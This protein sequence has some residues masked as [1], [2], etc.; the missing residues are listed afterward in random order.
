MHLAG[1]LDIMEDEAE[2]NE[3]KNESI[4]ES[5]NDQQKTCDKLKLTTNWSP[6]INP[7]VSS[8]ED[9]MWDK[10]NDIISQRKNR[11]ENDKCME[12]TTESQLLMDRNSPSISLFEIFNEDM[13]ADQYYEE[14]Q[15][16]VQPQTV[17]KLEKIEEE[18]DGEEFLQGHPMV[19]EDTSDKYFPQNSQ[20]PSTIEPSEISLD[21]LSAV[22]DEVDINSTDKPPAPSVTEIHCFKHG[23]EPVLAIN[24]FSEEF[25][26]FHCNNSKFTERMNDRGKVTKQIYIGGWTSSFVVLHSGDM[27]YTEFE[28]GTMQKVYKTGKVEEFWTT[29][30][31]MPLGVGLAL[32]GGLLVCLV[33]KDCYDVSEDSMRMVQHLTEE[34]HL[35][36]TYEYADDK[37]VRLFNF[38]YRV[39]ENFNTDI[40]VVDRQSKDVVIIKVVSFDRRLKFVYHGNE[41][42]KERFHPSGI[43]CDTYC[44][45]II[46]DFNNHCIHLLSD[47]GAF[48]K[49]LTTDTEGLKYPYCLSLYSNSRLWVGCKD[50][51]IRV[52]DYIT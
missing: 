48:L 14:I 19:S 4:G 41:N 40:C 36:E 51:V 1:S 2:F 38:P 46:T 16:I 10:G 8:D 33:D 42:T 47:E 24:A 43:V 6:D 52:Y 26:W 34:G 15:E 20:D 29:K 32:D 3:D 49:F 11:T 45:I 18:S 23:T 50:G 39:A 28:G 7:V 17:D 12:Q 30:P 25:T 5:E 9:D 27:V 37:R 35:T 44:N 13:A 21:E 22:I 31:L